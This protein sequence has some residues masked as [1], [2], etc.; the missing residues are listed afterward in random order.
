LIDAEAGLVNTACPVC[1]GGKT[2]LSYPLLQCDLYA[3]SS[4][5][6]VFSLPKEGVE[7]EA[8]PD[9]YFEER[10]REYFENPDTPLFERTLEHLERHWRRGGNVLDVGCGPGNWLE[11]LRSRS[12]RPYGVEISEAAAQLARQKG[13][14]V[15]CADIADYQPEVEMDGMISWYVLE[16][17]EEVDSFVAHS[18]GK[19]RPGGVAVFAT[20]DSGSLIYSMGKLL[21]RLSLGRFRAPLQRICEIH[22]VQ[23][24]TARSLSA[25][26]EKHGFEVLERFSA[27]F[28]VRSVNASA[29]QRLLLGIAGAMASVAGSHIIQ[30][31]IARSRRPTGLGV[32]ASGSGSQHP[33]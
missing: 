27:R 4:C 2:R 30:V 5:T 12:Y 18:A 22:H 26:L 14:E 15:T 9:D 21:H 19:L 31:A 29:A 8:Y 11:F 16:H 6:H 17:I 10:H 3:C 7:P 25:L 24:F 33:Q 28:P 32:L 1:G 23:H 20:V 13:L